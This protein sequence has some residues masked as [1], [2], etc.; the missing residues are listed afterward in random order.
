MSKYRRSPIFE[1]ISVVSGVSIKSLLL[2]WKP[3][4]CMVL[5]QFENFLKKSTVTPPTAKS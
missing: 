4:S 5:S 1:T 3:R 2:L